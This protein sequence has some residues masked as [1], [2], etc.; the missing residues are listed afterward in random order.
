MR[1]YP[2]ELEAGEILF[3][4]FAWWR[5]AKALEFSVTLTYANFRWPNAASA[6]Y[7]VG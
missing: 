5:Q 3:M 1:A 6:T 4:P 2:A 7:P